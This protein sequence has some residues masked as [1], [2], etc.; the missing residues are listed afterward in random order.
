MSSLGSM[1]TPERLDDPIGTPMKSHNDRHKEEHKARVV[2]PSMGCVG[3]RDAEVDGQTSSFLRIGSTK[4]RDSSVECG[5]S[6]RGTTPKRH[7]VSH[8]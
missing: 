8:K 7:D 6:Q 3:P 5:D 4:G 1:G 2:C